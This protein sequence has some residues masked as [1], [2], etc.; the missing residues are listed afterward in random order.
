MQHGPTSE[1]GRR[2]VSTASK[3]NDPCGQQQSDAKVLFFSGKDES[4]LMQLAGARGADG[5]IRKGQ[6]ASQVVAWIR[7]ILS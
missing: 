2:F 1:V 3:N 6:D 5:C 7:A 4:E